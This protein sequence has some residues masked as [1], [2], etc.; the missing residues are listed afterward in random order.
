M[1]APALKIEEVEKLF[2]NV[3]AVDKVSIEVNR[4][5]FFALLGPSGSGKTTLLR[6][7]AGLET[8][9]GGTVHIGGRD[10]TK[11]PPYARGI[12]MVFQDFLLFPH[13][14]VRENIDFPLKMQGLSVDRKKKQLTWVLSLVHMEGY[15]DRYP[16]QLSGGQKHQA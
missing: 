1:T 10:V 5:E 2:G 13:K 16:H 12:G 3:R 4:G 8:A 7:I 14:T 11:L 6:I 9:G 15:E